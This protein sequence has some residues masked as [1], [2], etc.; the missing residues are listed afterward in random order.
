MQ[1]SPLLLSATK[2]RTHL[3]HTVQHHQELFDTKVGQT[4]YIMPDC[5]VCNEQHMHVC[6]EK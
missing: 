4:K 2:I 6:D 5:A 1:H 3:Q